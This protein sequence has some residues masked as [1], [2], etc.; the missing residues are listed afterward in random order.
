MKASCKKVVLK[1]ITSLF[2]FLL[3]FLVLLSPSQ[4]SAAERSSYYDWGPYYNQTKVLGVTFSSL[5]ELPKIEIPANISPPPATGILP[6]SPFHFLETL[7][8]NAQ[9]SFIFDP[10]KKE[11]FRLT[12]ASERLSEAKTLVEQGNYQAAESAAAEYRNAMNIVSDNLRALSAQNNPQADA[13][14]ENVGKLSADHAVVAQSAALSSPSAA[15]TTWN[16][17]LTAS[18]KAMDSS[19]ETSGQPAIPEELSVSLQE[20]K[21]AGLITPEQSDKLYSLTSRSQ[22]RAEIDKLTAAGTFPQAEAAKLDTAVAVNY[23]DIYNQAL[24]VL[25]FA[26]LRSYQTLPPPSV[27]ILKEIEEWQAQKGDLPPPA[28][29]KPYLYHARASE[30]AQSIDFAPFSAD[31]QTEVAKF[32]PE[33]VSQNPTYTPPPSPSPLPSPEPSPTP[34]EQTAPETASPSEPT[35]PSTQPYLA[36]YNGPLP[37][38]PAYFFKQIGEG[39]GLFTAAFDPARRM[40][41]S[42]QFAEERLKEAN[43]LALATGREKDYQNTLER[44]KDSLEGIT[45]NLRD[46]QGSEETRRDLAGK[47]EAEAARHNVIFEKGLLPPVSENT[48]VMPAV[49]AVTQNAM[50]ASA[51]ALDKPAIPLSLVA[52]LQDLKAQGQLLPEEVDNIVQSQS[53]EEVRE[54]IRELV[55]LETFPPAD[56]KK[57]DEA[58]AIV[59]PHDYNQLVEVKKVEE[60]QRLRAAQA[61]FAQTATLRQTNANY[62]TRIEFLTKSI[63]PSLI[64]AEDLAGR[65][66]LLATYQDLLSKSGERPINAGQFVEAEKTTSEEKNTAIRPVDAVFSTCPVGAI[67]KQFEGCVWE[68]NGSKINNYEQYKCSTSKE[69]WSFSQ[70]KCVLYTPGAEARDTQ[71][72]CPIGY[73]WA[74]ESQN[75]QVSNTPVP[76]PP[77][78]VLPIGDLPESEKENFC[79]A[80]ASYQ[81]GKGCLWDNSQKSVYDPAQYR[82]TPGAYYSFSEFKCVENPDPSQPYPKNTQ[83][84]CSEGSAWSWTDGRCLEVRSYTPVS[85]A[86]SKLQ[87]PQ[88]SFAGPDSPLYGLKRAFEGI[89]TF[90]AFTTQ[91]RQEVRLAHAKERFAEAYQ[92]LEANDEEGFKESLSLY[93]GEM[94]QVYNDLASANFNDEARKQLGEALET[95]AL[96]QNLLLQKVSVFASAD[97]ATPISAA[98]SVTVQGVDRAADLQGQPAIPEEIKTKIEALPADMISDE[99]KQKLLATNN[100]VKARLEINSLVGQGFLTNQDTALLDESLTNSDPA[101][102]A[103]LDELKK[104]DE[105][106][107]L[108]KLTGEIDKTVEKNENIAQKLEEFRQSFTP[109]QEIPGEIRPYVRLTRIEEITQTIRPDIVRTEDFGNRRDLQLAVATLKEEFKPTRETVDRLEQYRRNNPGR[110]LPFDLARAE[111]FSRGLGVRNEAGPCYLPSPPF[112]PNTPCPAPGS[113]IPI[114]SYDN[115]AFGSSA[116]GTNTNITN[117]AQGKP[118]VYGDGPKPVEAGVC[119]DNYH[120]MYDNGGW[121]MSSSGSYGGSTTSYGSPSVTTPGYTPYTSYYSPPGA[122]P[123]SYGYQ[124]PG[125]YSNNYY[126][127]TG[128]PYTP[129][130]YY[131]TAP[132]TY[133][134][135]PPPGT[136]PGSGPA[137]STGGE[138]PSGFHWM[139]PSY[140]QGGWCMSNGGTY[141]PG[142]QYGGG[143]AQVSPGTQCPKGTYWNSYSSSCQSPTS[144]T[145]PGGSGNCPPGQYWTGSSTGGGSCVT[146]DTWPSPNLTRESCG[147]GYYWSG[148]A[149]YPNYPGSGGGSTSSCTYPS[150]GCG[151]GYFDYGSCSCKASSSQGCYNVSASSCPSG[152]YFDSAACTCRQSSTSTPGSGGGTTSG[153]CPSGSHWMSDNGGYCMS[154]AA[155]DGSTSGGSTTTGGSTSSGSCPSGYH[156]MS[157]SGGWCMSDN[158]SGGGSTSTYTPPPTTTSTEP[159]PAPTTTEPAPAP[160]PTEPAPAPT[161]SP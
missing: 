89:Q 62:E 23:P 96:E 94:Q 130:T 39:A 65:E 155:R 126:S 117:D 103:K 59:T 98:V 151:S 144:P 150:G 27:D 28:E 24:S 41:L 88:P 143:G 159:T 122:P 129:P 3:T 118:L 142:Y 124:G 15:N 131:G 36:D 74:W 31:Q 51:D 127:T 115:I 30:L 25:K 102:T 156:W 49:V 112:A 80:G 5:E 21:N 53:R 55:K 133:T 83:P 120:W 121:C 40:E 2:C 141:T 22:V 29:I 33:A 93:T 70:N 43:A 101:G 67:F 111:A 81:A 110:P 138:C 57:L 146:S 9:L 84:A 152:W 90:T 148:N 109:G 71:P 119:P 61:E 12:L 77:P 104:L 107:D 153:S 145:Y 50:D 76:T 63:D 137:P 79:P 4:I 134:T 56:A 161:T 19:A 95:Q 35:T 18:E 32:Y 34:T 116:F 13:L 14:A 68:A 157:D 85:D 125:N 69:Y 20:L 48:E 37:G 140:N 73:A 160:A 64:K 100:R 54:K 108:T 45:Q 123:A 139:P 135:N 82:C 91:A 105:I 8:E 66:G 136:V 46:Y 60:L 58:Q 99:D 44:Y 75:C 158:T 72:V 147:P 1:S 47:F 52:R 132:T 97:L 26:E 92:E 38:S 7:T 42:M 86:A 78:G 16:Q 10:V 87:V 106:V 17:L 149:C 154:D 113:A 114:F 11:E 128:S 6:G